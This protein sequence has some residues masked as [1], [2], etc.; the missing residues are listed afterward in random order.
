MSEKSAFRP[1]YSTGLEP[2]PYLPGRMEQRVVTELHTHGDDAFLD[3]LTRAGFRRSQNF[4]YRPA[5]PHC[6][7]CIPVRI[8]VDG[9]DWSRRWR[10]LW[11]RNAD[12]AA[13]ERSALATDEQYALFR[14][15]IE[16][17]HDEGGMAAMRWP[18]YREMV[19]QAPAST[20]LVELRDQ[21]GDLVGVSLTDRM[22][23]GLS[24]V[25]K[26]FDPSQP[27]RSLGSFLI[28]WHVERARSLGLPYVYLGYWI[29]ECRKMAYK[30][31]FR[32][33]ERLDRHGWRRIDDTSEEATGDGQDES[34]R[35]RDKTL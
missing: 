15:Y 9:F 16:D 28:L 11:H 33:L 2:C 18:D 6:R 12:L 30:D 31:Q 14:R 3:Q 1:F 32:P 5:C 35:R 17:R 24:G 10:K 20:M 7:A 4:L 21:G 13:G 23:S 19:E 22:G 29:K 27:R 25:Y 26:F 34:R 8:C